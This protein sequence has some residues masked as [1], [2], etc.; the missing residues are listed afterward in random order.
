M[1]YVHAISELERSESDR[2]ADPK[3]EH[4][5]LVVSS[6]STALLNA[7]EVTRLM[8]EGL[9]EKEGEGPRHR[10]FL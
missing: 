3:F 7:T 8:K 4:H 9:S 2:S 6:A 5:T 1:A 10:S